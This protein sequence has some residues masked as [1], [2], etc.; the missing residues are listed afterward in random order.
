MEANEV[1]DPFG[2]RKFCFEQSGETFS[3]V[4]GHGTEQNPIL[5]EADKNFADLEE[6]IIP[7]VCWCGNP[8]TKNK[9]RIEKN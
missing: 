8:K 4:S 9:T 2:I 7:F 1:V 6:K 5:F 3:I